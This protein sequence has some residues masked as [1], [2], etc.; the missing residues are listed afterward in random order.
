MWQFIINHTDKLSVV[1]RPGLTN[2]PRSRCCILRST[3]SIGIAYQK[4]CISIVNS[5]AARG[6]NR[7]LVRFESSRCEIDAIGFTKTRST[8]W[9]ST[10]WLLE[11]A[12]TAL[13]V[14]GGDCWWWNA[15]TDGR[16]VCITCMIGRSM[17]NRCTRSQTVPIDCGDRWGCWGDR[18]GAHSESVK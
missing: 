14:S 2:L 15:R 8:D 17:L 6:A 4:R 7:W 16:W 10:T 13:V 9:S 11:E 18:A 3:S 5:T 1:R 12:R